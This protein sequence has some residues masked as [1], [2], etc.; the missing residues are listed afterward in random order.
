MEQAEV[1]VLVNELETRL[2]RLRALYDQYFSGIE[3]LEP[4]V[5]RKDVD[6]RFDQLR[7]EQIR[8]TALR[9]R[10]Q[11]LVQK[12]NTYQSY[13]LRISRQIENGTY[14]RDVERAKAKF[15]VD[16]K[17]RVVGTGSKDATAK[18]GARARD[19]KEKES[20]PPSSPSWDLDMDAMYDDVDPLPSSADPFSDFDRLMAPSVAPGKPEPAKPTI[21]KPAEPTRSVPLKPIP[22]PSPLAAGSRDPRAA[23]P[24]VPARADTPSVKPAGRVRVVPAGQSQRPSERGDAASVPPAPARPAAEPVDPAKRVAF[25]P[26]PDVSATRTVPPVGAVPPPPVR[27]PA[28]RPAPAVDPKTAPVARP[29]PRAPIPAVP[30][31][32]ASAPSSTSGPAAKPATPAATA[33]KPA[34]RI[35]PAGSTPA[36]PIIRPITPPSTP[37]GG[38]GT[39]KD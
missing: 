37:G 1:E 28:A 11:M 20:A 25:R 17:G 9:F 31:A 18:R 6:R 30:A 10:F 13:W 35:A 26:S 33:P 15:G 7:R 39:K 32:P 21:A 4:S 24:S 14:K 12:Y 34:V 38:T 22:V 8:N 29:V 5:P 16:E 3:K 2:D 23:T 19:G 27:A 36:R